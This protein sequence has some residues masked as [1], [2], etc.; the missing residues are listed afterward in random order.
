MCVKQR[1]FG[2]LYD[3]FGDNVALRQLTRHFLSQQ[4][5]EDGAS[6]L[7][8]A[9]NLELDDTEIADDKFTALKGEQTNSSALIGDQILL[10][11]FRQPQAGI[12]PDIEINDFLSSRLPNAPKQYGLVTIDDSLNEWTIGMLQ[13]AVRNQGDGWQVTIDYLT[14][15]IKDD[16]NNFSYYLELAR[17]LGQRT[18]EMHNALAEGTDQD[19]RPETVT[20]DDRA[21]LIQNAQDTASKA[22]LHLL[23]ALPRLNDKNRQQAED[24]LSLWDNIAITLEKS[25]PVD[26]A[27]KKTRVH[28]DY[29]LG[30]V[31]VTENDFTIIDFEGEPTRTLEE[32]RSK[33]LPYKDVAGMVRSFHYAAITSLKQNED[34]AVSANAEALT[35][36]WYHQA[37][38][39][40]LDQ[41]LETAVQTL[42]K[43]EQEKIIRFFTLE[44]ALYELSYEAQRRPDWISIPLEGL[45]QLLK[46]NGTA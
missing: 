10:K 38:N 23:Q 11:L 19:F 15:Q 34:N 9:S 45:A 29:H 27:A 37:K 14:R 33:N 8:F 12:N 5:I 40:F 18:A 4:K 36:D 31:L 41:Y 46:D 3:A 22:K 26:I 13:Q 35:L 24:I 32:R 20:K 28:G 2:V 1:A 6:S 44:K 25:F 30:Q 17:K 21:H 16:N 7:T 43:N 42:N 39:I